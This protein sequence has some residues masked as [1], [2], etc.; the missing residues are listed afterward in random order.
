MLHKI[1]KKV[2][3]KNKNK[4]KTITKE[5]N[6]KYQRNCHKKIILRFSFQAVV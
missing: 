2:N 4:N 5:N 3:F 1:R 6:P